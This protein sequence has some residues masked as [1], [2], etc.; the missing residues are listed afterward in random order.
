MR[1]N[2]ITYNSYNHSEI[3]VLKGIYLGNVL[4]VVSDRKIAVDDNNDNI[5][6][7]YLTDI[8][9]STD[10]FCFGGK[11]PSRSYN[12]NAYKYSFNGKEDDQETDLEDYGERMYNSALG[13]FISVDPLDK[14]YPHFS[15]YHYAGNNPVAFIDL[16]GAETRET[17]TPATNGKL[18]QDGT[19]PFINAEYLVAKATKANKP[20]PQPVIQ[21][22][23]LQSQKEAM[24]FRA[25]QNQEN[26]FTG[27][28]DFNR[29]MITNPVIQETAKGMLF[30]GMGTA[31]SGLVPRISAGL[32]TMYSSTSARAVQNYLLAGTLNATG[33]FIGQAAITRD[34]RDIDKADIG[35]AFIFNKASMKNAF[36]GASF[37]SIF[38]IKSNGSDKDVYFGIGKSYGNV[39][40]DFGTNFALNTLNYKIS[41]FNIG[42]TLPFVTGAVSGGGQAAVT[43]ILFPP[44]KTSELFK[45]KPAQQEVLQKPQ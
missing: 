41:K 43:N 31:V 5:V 8:V 25:Y 40:W 3:P 21:T 20:S 12:S 22:W 33:N 27:M 34:L 23:S 6:D 11:M 10:Y 30:V 4:T 15:P 14:N 39:A 17:A 45:Q 36:L 19:A 26:Y 29:G 38:D 32:N 37:S 18:A 16:D 9:S 13:K 28:S 44:E 1:Y 7:Y 24:M 2:T 35:F 42:E